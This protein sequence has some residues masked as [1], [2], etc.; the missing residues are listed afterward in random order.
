MTEKNGQNDRLQKKKTL[1]RTRN[2]SGL[3]TFEEC[4]GYTE[5]NLKQLPGEKKQCYR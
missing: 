5:N 4:K 1:I 2:W 3:Y